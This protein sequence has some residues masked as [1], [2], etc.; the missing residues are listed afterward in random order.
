[1]L[2]S[3]R[4]TV[5][6]TLPKIDATD[7]APARPLTNA[8]WCE[9][10]YCSA[11]GDPERVP[12]GRCGP[13]GL[14][15]KWLSSDAPRLVRPGCRTVVVGCGLGDDVAE[16]AAR[17]FDVVGFD[18]STSAVRWAARRFPSH[19]NRFL[20]SDLLDLPARMVGR[21]DLVV[22]ICTLQS[23]APELRKTAAGSLARL[24][25]PRGVILAISCGKH[26]EENGPEE[27]P[28]WPL[29]ADELE[30]LMAGAGLA[31]MRPVVEVPCI[32]DPDHVRV[33]GA[34]IRG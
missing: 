26:A 12:W 7:L 28:P 6:D 20:V 21:F 31:S 29:S 1:M 25:A 22:E 3:N 16:L 2:D 19:A 24:A 27:G 33:M 14:L 30:S 34:F 4:S 32:D 9:S 23:V 11:A 5:P 13:D 15:L 17:G 18:V 8:E 10:V